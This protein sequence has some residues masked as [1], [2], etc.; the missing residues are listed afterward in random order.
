ME[1]FGTTKRLGVM[2]GAFNPM[3]LGHLRAAEEMCESYSLERVYFLPTALAPHKPGYEMAPFDHRYRMVELAVSGR[4]SFVA[5]DLE[6][7][8]PGPSY[9]VNTLKFLRKELIEGAKLY[10]LVGFDS[11]SNI[12]MWHKFSELFTLTSFVVHTRPETQSS[13]ELLGAFLTQL[14]GHTPQW[15]D[16]KKAYL[17]VGLEPIYYFEGAKL[18]ISSTDIRRRIKRGESV[19]YLVPDA[20]YEYLARHRLYAGAAN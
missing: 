6:A 13:I 2:G 9:T 11:F 12:G 18:A 19:R 3:H 20:V 7:R 15:S 8:L 10:F 14:F 5:S 16:D 1:P 17:F 4:E